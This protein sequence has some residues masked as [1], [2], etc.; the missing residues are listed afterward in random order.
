[1]AEAE[2]EVKATCLKDKDGK[3]YLD[4]L[5]SNAGNPTDL[6]TGECGIFCQVDFAYIMSKRTKDILEGKES[7]YKPLN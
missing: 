5:D 1:M 4:E 2:R 6:I 7:I 3:I